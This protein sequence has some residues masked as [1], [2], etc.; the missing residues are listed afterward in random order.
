ML[1]NHVLRYGAVPP[2]SAA[3][4]DDHTPTLVERASVG[5]CSAITVEWIDACIAQTTR[6]MDWARKSVHGL[7]VRMR[8]TG[9]TMT[10]TASAQS[11][12]CLLRPM[13]SDRAPQRGRTMMATTW[14]PRLAM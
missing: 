1:V 14:A 8:L 7:S 2:V 4:T 13:R 5:A 12:I 9:N 10:M 11:L 6:A 3:P